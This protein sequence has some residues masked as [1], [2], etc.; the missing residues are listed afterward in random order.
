MAYCMVITT[1][2]TQ[3]E[4]RRLSEIMVTSKLAACVQIHPVESIYSWQGS[5][6]HEPEFRLILKTRDHLYHRIESM[7]I[8]HHSY[9]VPQIIQ[10]AIDNGSED[11][12]AWINDETAD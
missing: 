2:A 12:L 9:D 5:V 1:C 10:V 3:E 8:Q 7:I 6:H 4:A 11:Y